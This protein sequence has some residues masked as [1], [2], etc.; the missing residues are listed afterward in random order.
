MSDSNR[1]FGSVSEL[2]HGIDYMPDS[3]YEFGSNV[4][5]EPKDSTLLNH[6]KSWYA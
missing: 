2:N 3:D 5:S 6:T 4:D 1:D